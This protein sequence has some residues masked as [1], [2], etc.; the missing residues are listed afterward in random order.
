[1][2]VW[3]YIVTDSLWIKPTDVLKCNF[4]GITTVHV[5]G[6]LSAHHQEFL[7]VH[8]PWYILCSCD[9][10][11]L[12]GVGWHAYHPTPGSIRSSQLHKMYQT[13]SK[14]SRCVSIQLV[15][16]FTSNTTIN[17][18]IHTIK[19]YKFNGYMFRSPLRLLQIVRLQCAY[20]MGSHILSTLKAHDL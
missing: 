1:M 5:S 20:S 19:R 2:V 15:Y 13:L 17:I 8:R 11:L 16:I 6:S 7:T 9:D 14:P 3:P 12:Q 4:I 18:I 10:R